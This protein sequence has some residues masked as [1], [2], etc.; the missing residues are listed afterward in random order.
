M[1]GPLEGFGSVRRKTGLNTIFCGGL[2]RYTPDCIFFFTS[3]LKMNI[4]KKKFSS[5]SR[6]E[7]DVD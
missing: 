6:G 5:G 1:N 4:V 2:K 7:T 3:L